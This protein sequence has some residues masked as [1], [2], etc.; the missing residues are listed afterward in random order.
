LI[1]AICAAGPPQARAPNLRNRQ[2]IDRR[3]SVP[4]RRPTGAE[5][6]GS[7]GSERGTTEREPYAVVD[8]AAAE[9]ESRNRRVE[10]V[11]GA[12]HEDD[13]RSL[14]RIYD[15]M[16]REDVEAFVGDVAHDIEWNLPEAVPWGGTRHGQDGMRAL[17][18]IYQQHVE[19]T[20]ADPDDFLDA[21]DR[22]VV[23]GRMRG[24]ARSSGAE[25]EV[26]FA[27]VW[28]LTD[29]VPSWFRGY[30][31]TEPILAALRASGR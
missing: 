12:M 10:L 21:G 1:I 15:A 7:I 24:C 5:A 6:G 26:E 30:F 4:F 22:V 8:R 27:H 13:V 19:G 28:A 11:Q 14:R 9:D 17:A 2:K 25:F 3:R 20:W 29:G 18:E 23:L 31:D 16:S